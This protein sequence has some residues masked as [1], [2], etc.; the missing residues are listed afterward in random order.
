LA[1]IKTRWRAVGRLTDAD[2]RRVAGFAVQGRLGEGGMGVVYLAE[3]PR[4][5]P[6]A[7]KFVHA[8]A[9]A[10]AT[11]RARFRREVEAANR[12]SGPRVARVLAADLDAE[13]PW[14]A[15]SF[16]D[17]PTLAEAVGDGHPMSGDRLLAL[18]AALA[19][20]LRAIHAAGVVH[21]DLKPANI[22]L[23]PETP[24]VIDFGIAAAR[25]AP[26]LTKTGMQL[27]TPGWMAPEQVRG[28]RAGPATDVFAWGLVV[29]YA[30][31]GRPPFGRGPADALYYRVVHQRPRLPELLPPLDR[32]VPAAL[33]KDPRLRPTVADLV[34]GLEAGPEGVDDASSGPT[35]GSVPTIVAAGWGPEALPPD[36]PRPPAPG[37]PTDL[38][39][40]AVPTTGGPG[41]A[42]AAGAAPAAGPAGNGAAAGAAGAA[43]AAVGGAAGAAGANGVHG[44][45]SNGEAAADP[46]GPG[47]LT[48]ATVA[49]A[50][51][52]ARPRPNAMPGGALRRPDDATRVVPRPGPGFFFAGV[53]H[54]DPV[55]LA[56][57]F[58][59]GWDQAIDQVFIRRDPV[60]IADLEAF[61]RTRGLR[62]AERI[63]SA[64][65]GHDTPLPA[66]M[67]RLVAAVD[68]EAEPRVG[69]L[70]LTPAGLASAAHAVADGK[71][72]AE[73]AAARLAEV[74]DA[75]LLRLWRG[76]PGME[77]AAAVDERWQANTHAYQRLLERV[78][79]NGGVPAPSPA[80]RSVADARLLLCALGGRHEKQQAR[81]LRSAKRSAA[82][83]VSWWRALA[84][85]GSGSAAATV[86]ALVAAPRAREVGEG[87]RQAEA[88]RR[89][90]EDQA[91]R[92]AEAARRAQEEQARRL[93]EA[94]RAARPAPPPP[95]GQAY[96]PPPP[97][98]PG[99]APRAAARAARLRPTPNAR[100]FVSKPFGLV[101]TAVILIGHLWVLGALGDDLQQFYDTEDGIGLG[102]SESAFHGVEDATGFV[103]FVVLLAVGFHVLTRAVD[104]GSRPA[105]V[106]AYALGAAVVDGLVALAFYVTV[107]LA[108]LVVEATA[109]AP[110]ADQFPRGALRPGWGGLVVT[111]GVVAVLALFLAIRAAY[112]FLRA[113]FGGTV[114]Y[115]VHHPVY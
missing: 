69:D 13:V 48:A 21:R 62:D 70:L 79:N 15:T 40:R 113:L 92:Q 58:Q 44:A 26:E 106:R 104:K 1:D 36:G 59:D 75:R 54:H 31:S 86:A 28:R 114:G 43:G 46:G 42:G 93:A 88:A 5:G 81:Q 76:Q 67:A 25:E 82:T 47:G 51:A 6:A 14:L 7:L 60:W 10:D 102:R 37:A 33:T 29:A 94:Q 32:L 73:Q 30:A 45:R 64:G 66:T 85:E 110:W 83:D 12:V 19:D 80:E 72:G 22:L 84:D 24:V 63:V 107:A 61:L 91:R 78:V 4:M 90:Q 17:G 50:G 16:V 96:R 97:A 98:A 71:K 8:A 52:G 105:V 115:P 3:H 65:R 111:H 108:V 77:H 34:A 2:P 99:A 95:P 103:V 53:E 49:A 41:A 74:R 9:A 39:R 89:A 56:A 38:T 100:S 27:G 57:A 101:V 68:P 109:Q 112:R 87:I 11:F 35:T 20:A 55:T 18:A 23:T